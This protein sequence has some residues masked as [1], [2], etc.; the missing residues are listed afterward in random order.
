MIGS[1]KMF[2]TNMYKKKKETRVNT[3][4][5]ILLS[6]HIFVLTTINKETNNMCVNVLSF[7]AGLIA[8]S[9]VIVSFSHINA[10]YIIIINTSR[11]CVCNRVFFFLRRVLVCISLNNGQRQHNMEIESFVQSILC[12]L[13]FAFAIKFFE[14]RLWNIYWPSFFIPLMAARKVFVLRHVVRTF[15]FENLVF[16]W[17]W[18]LN[19]E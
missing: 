16:F 7:I 10:I 14:Y 11:A 15:L 8:I 17:F 18:F 13:L 2:D 3:F 5:W 19:I 4:K 12:S 9:T 6:R 1:I